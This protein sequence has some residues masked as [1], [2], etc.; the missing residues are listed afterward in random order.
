MLAAALWLVN[1][2]VIPVNPAHTVRGPRHVVTSGQTSV[3][4]PAKARALLDSIDASNVAHV[5]D[6]A[7]IAL[8][9]AAARETEPPAACP[10]EGGTVRRCPAAADF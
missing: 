2:Q 4:D 9:G 1:C 5:L 10:T 8:M 6:R 7:L 3:L